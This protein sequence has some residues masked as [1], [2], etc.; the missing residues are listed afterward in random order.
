MQFSNS[1]AASFENASPYP[2]NGH[3][4]PAAS[5]SNTIY[6]SV[7]TFNKGIDNLKDT[8]THTIQQNGHSKIELTKVIFM[9]GEQDPAR[10][11]IYCNNQFLFNLGRFEP[12]KS[13]DFIVAAINRY[14]VFNNSELELKVNSRKP[15]KV[16]LHYQYHNKNA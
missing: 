14:I 13:E 4:V 8:I 7:L 5:H 15:F 2:S 3:E 10:I 11:T 12:S 9:D 6:S 16:I 1:N